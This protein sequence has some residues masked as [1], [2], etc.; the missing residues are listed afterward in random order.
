MIEENKNKEA[1]SENSFISVPNTESLPSTSTHNTTPGPLYEN[2][3]KNSSPVYQNLEEVKN[4]KG[5]NQSFRAELTFDKDVS[6]SSI[7]LADH[8][9]RKRRYDVFFEVL[10]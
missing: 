8:V 1:S 2:L 10:N 5:D 9:S 3:A 6:T 7:G 4:N